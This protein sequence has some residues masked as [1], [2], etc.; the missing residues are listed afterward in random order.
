MRCT[1][2]DRSGNSLNVVKF[3]P[4]HYIDLEVRRDVLS[5]L[6][7]DLS[8]S[9]SSILYVFQKH[10]SPSTFPFLSEHDRDMFVIID[11]IK[12]LKN[13][14]DRRFFVLKSFATKSFKDDEFDNN[15]LREKYATLGA[16]LSD[17]DSSEYF[18]EHA[19]WGTHENDPNEF[20]ERNYLRTFE[21]IN[22]T[23]HGTGIKENVMLVEKNGAFERI[24]SDYQTTDSNVFE[25]IHTLS[26]RC[27]SFLIAY[28]LLKSSI[29]WD[30]MLQ[31]ARD[32]FSKKYH[33]M[34]TDTVQS[35]KS[36]GS[37]GVRRFMRSLSL[38]QKSNLQSNHSLE[39]IPSI[40]TTTTTITTT[41][42]T[43]ASD[44]IAPTPMV[45]VS[46]APFENDDRIG[47]ND[48]SD[49]SALTFSSSANTLSESSTTTTTPMD[50]PRAI[51]PRK[52]I[53]PRHVFEN[54]SNVL[55]HSISSFQS[56]GGNDIENMENDDA[57]STKLSSHFPSF[58]SSFESTT[59]TS[60]QKKDL[61]DL[62][63]LLKTASRLWDT[64]VDNFV[65]PENVNAMGKAFLYRN[66]FI[67]SYRL[68]FFEY[69]KFISK[70]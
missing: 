62:E 19:E 12:R 64:I 40:A 10:V 59:M 52:K 63:I 42:T 55:S 25:R 9:L 38:Q 17:D 21:K 50:S 39:K 13:D 14:V 30:D 56:T 66:E 4:I 1:Y 69:N 27:R 33:Q 23:H 44:T 7:P 57:P 51:S 48:T 29:L 58:V 37:L 36:S 28:C 41:T 18:N 68:T 65:L 61:Q 67:E 31:D 45:M 15:G 47:M 60:T 70:M 3:T 22:P 11:S 54:I 20:R 34:P 8:E 43:T 32:I 26:L 5:K 2:K 53:S 35:R 16:S 24:V 46:S 6:I 49:G